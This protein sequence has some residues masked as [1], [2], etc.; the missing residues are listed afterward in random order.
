MENTQS[1]ASPSCIIHSIMKNSSKESYQFLFIMHIW[2][3]SSGFW[4][5]PIYTKAFCEA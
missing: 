5:S 2:I 4:D 1:L 3:D